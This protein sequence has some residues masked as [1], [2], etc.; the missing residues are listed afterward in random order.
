MRWLG[1][2]IIPDTPYP[3]F[4]LACPVSGRSRRC[5]ITK[6]LIEVYLLLKAINAASA[7][8]RPLRL[9]HPL[10]FPLRRARRSPA[11]RRAVLFA[12]LVDRPSS[13]LEELAIDESQAS[14]R[15]DLQGIFKCTAPWKTSGN[16]LILGAARY[17]IVRS[18]A[19]GRREALRRNNAEAVPERGAPR[20][21]PQC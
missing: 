19:Q 12:Q 6:D 7:N 5:R 20:T 3:L 10:T 18:I 16:T 8:E 9:A 1:P 4:K 2:F 11:A 13:Q 17:E 21:C 14:K 15:Q